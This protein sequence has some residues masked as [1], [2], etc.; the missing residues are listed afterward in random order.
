[1]SVY[2]SLMKVYLKL[3][4]LLEII[5]LGREDFDSKIVEFLLWAIQK[6]LV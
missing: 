5:H 4:L 1:M 6:K 2:W 3:K